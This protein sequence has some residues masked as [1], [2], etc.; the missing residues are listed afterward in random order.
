MYRKFLG[1]MY[2]VAFL[3][4]SPRE[5]VY[6]LGQTLVHSF[7]NHI[8]G[9]A[10]HRATPSMCG[11]NHLRQLSIGGEHDFA[12]LSRLQRW[13][14]HHL[15]HGAPSWRCRSQRPGRCFRGSS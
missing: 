13:P 1:L 9:V 5:L 4:L 8:S 2:M 3:L 15:Q 6:M 7:G 12:S 10:M 14:P 11:T